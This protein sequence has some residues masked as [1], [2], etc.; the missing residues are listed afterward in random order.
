MDV[1]PSLTYRDLEA[2]LEFLENAFG[3][4]PEVLGTDEQGAIRHAALRHGEG[5]S[6]APA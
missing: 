1:Y 4:E 6:T 2:A 5:V 3:L